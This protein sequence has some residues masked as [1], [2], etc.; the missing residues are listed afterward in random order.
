M[1]EAGAANNLLRDARQSRVKESAN[2]RHWVRQ[3]QLTTCMRDA[4]QSRV[5]GEHDHQMR[6]LSEARA[7]VTS[8]LYERCASDPG[9]KESTSSD[10]AT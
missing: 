2:I 6:N 9:L 1:G 8:H 7:A 10:E 5:E 3:E 4:R